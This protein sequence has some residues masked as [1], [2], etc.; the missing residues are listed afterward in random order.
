MK[1]A[2]FEVSKKRQDFLKGFLNSEEVSFFEE[3]LNESNVDLIKDVDV[4]SVFVDSD[5]NKNVIEKIPNLKF[6]ATQSTGFN[7]IDCEYAFEKGIKVSN[8]PAYGSHTVA[9]FTFGLILNLSRNI[10]NA[11]NYLR[12]TLNYDYLPWMEG[13]NLEGKTIGIIGTGKIGKNVV[14]IAKGFEMN[15][16]AYDLYPDLAF[17]KENNFE[18][19]NF[20]EV[21][22]SSDIITLHAPYTKENHHL[23][24]KESILKM[25]K[26]VY[27]INT[28]RGELIDTEALVWGLEE[29]IIAGAGLDV[30]EGVKKIKNDENMMILNHKLM[31]MPNVM[32]SPHM[33]FFTR[34]AIL[35]IMQTTVDNIKGFI[36]GNLQNLVK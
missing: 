11:N 34:E 21:L 7:H 35:S 4:V 16:L 20:D 22:S 32:V 8:V 3:K 14:K 6:I 10:S 24:N 29:K 27:I 12:E 2:F 9:E 19:K 15:V 13:F 18:Y 1:I 30:L 17:A 25:K 31:K 26:G 28:A 36:S 33:A 23:I 5:L